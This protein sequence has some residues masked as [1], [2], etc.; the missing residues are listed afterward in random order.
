MP[1]DMP[2]AAVPA[3]WPTHF[4]AIAFGSGFVVMLAALLILGTFTPTIPAV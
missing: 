4:R 2:A 3:A 1:S